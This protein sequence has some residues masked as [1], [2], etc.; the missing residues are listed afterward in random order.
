MQTSHDIGW[1]HL[2][3]FS[4][5]LII[6]FSINKVY[7]LELGREMATAIARMA[8]QLILV[9]LYLEFVFSTNNPWI[10]LAWITVMLCVGATTIVGKSKL[11]RRVLFAPVLTGLVVGLA[12]VLA[13]LCWLVVQPVP[14]YNAQ[15]VIPLAGMLLGNSLSGNIVALQ[16][17]YTAFEE[18][19]HEYAVAIALGAPPAYASLPFVRVAMQKAFAPILASMAATGLVTLPGMMTGQ[20]LGGASPMLAIKYQL[21][22]LLAIFVMMSISVTLTLKLS[23]YRSINPQGRVTIGFKK[24]NQN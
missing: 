23:L 7:K 18:R 8:S 14:I 24:R 11:P 22:I 9:G 4:L 13:I 2:A 12:P 17:L 6:P 16:N 10:N 3:A 15:Y 1:W 21:V 19:H 5:L 20:I